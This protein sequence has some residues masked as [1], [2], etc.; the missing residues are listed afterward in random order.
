[1]HIYHHSQFNDIPDPAHWTRW[2]CH[3]TS[4]HPNAA[5]S[6]ALDHVSLSCNWVLTSRGGLDLPLPLFVLLRFLSID[7]LSTFGLLGRL[8]LLSQLY[9]SN[10]PRV[11]PIAIGSLVFTSRRLWGISFSGLPDHLPI[12]SRY[13]LANIGNP[14]LAIRQPLSWQLCTNRESNRS[15]MHVYI[16]RG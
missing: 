6:E 1:M 12:R 13:P 5:P 4:P 9:P 11:Y 10:D 15:G 16:G 7:R 8:N 14:R 2:L 3:P